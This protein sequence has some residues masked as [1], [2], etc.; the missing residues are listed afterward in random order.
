MTEKYLLDAN[1]LST[2]KII[3]IRMKSFLEFGN[4]SNCSQSNKYFLVLIRFMTN[5]LKGMI[6]LTNGQRRTA[7]C[8]LI[9]EQTVSHILMK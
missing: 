2:Q 7:I 6:S 9:Q 8:S 1:I 5:F 4:C 3:I